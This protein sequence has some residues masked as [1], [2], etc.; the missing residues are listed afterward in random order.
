[1]LTPDTGQEPLGRGEFTILWRALRCG[2]TDFFHI[3]RED[4][5]GTCPNQGGAD[6]EMRILH[7]PLTI[8]LA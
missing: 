3:E 7:P 2:V 6:D 4:L 5:M 8:G 1:M